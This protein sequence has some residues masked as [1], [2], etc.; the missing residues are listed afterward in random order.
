MELAAGLSGGGLR[1]PVG[2][3]CGRV[4][5]VN[6]YAQ[7]PD[8]LPFLGGDDEGDGGRDVQRRALA[9]RLERAYLADSFRA[10][11]S[12]GPVD[13]SSRGCRPVP[14]TG[15]GGNLSHEVEAAEP[16]EHRDCNIDSLRNLARMAEGAWPRRD[17]GPGSRA[18]GSRGRGSSFPA[19][20]A[21]FV[22]RFWSHEDMA[23]RYYQTAVMRRPFDVDVL[24]RY[25]EFSWQR[26]RNHMQAE[27]LFGQALEE[28]PQNVSALA[29][30]ALF[31][32]ESESATQGG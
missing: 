19:D 8:S 1:P 27:T 26:K 31:L 22:D 29:S 13:C 24:I 9:A 15:A 21:E 28:E 17:A 14:C 23:D 10:E 6:N 7:V 11:A 30:Y 4:V 5:R 2:H 18:Q 32:W 12:C 16:V 3:R 25:A 20:F